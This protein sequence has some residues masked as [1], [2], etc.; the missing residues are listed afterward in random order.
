MPSAF[1]PSGPR[2][3]QPPP[4]CA[5][6]RSPR[7]PTALAAL[8][9]LM[10]STLGPVA[11]AQPGKPGK[12]TAPTPRPAGA[13]P[14]KPGAPKAAGAAPKARAPAPAKPGDAK[15]E[16]ET[17]AQVRWTATTPDEMLKL[18]LERA[19][20]AGTD[21]AAGL[22]VASYLDERAEQGAARKGLLALAG[23][24]LAP[25]LADDA[26]WLAKW[27]T[28]SPAGEPWSGL[29]NVAYDPG[30]DADGLV[31]AFAVLGPF[32][33]TGGG[34]ERKEGPEA[35]GAKL[36][37]MSARYSW[38]VY[39]VAWRRALPSSVTA[40][41]L[42]LDLY[43]HPRT[44]SCSYLAS[45]VRLP[46]HKG[47]VLLHVAASGAVRV[48]WDGVDVAMSSEQHPKA[49]MDRLALALDDAADGEPHLLV[50]KSCTAATADSGHVRARFTDASYQPVAVEASSGLAGFVPKGS[51]SEKADK[52]GKPGAVGKPGGK[53]DPPKGAPGATPAQAPKGTPGKGAKGAPAPGAK[54]AKGAA[55]A[56]RL[57]IRLP[58][59]VARVPTTLERALE[60][61]SEPSHERALVGAVAR[62]FGGAEDA[63]SPRAP[64]LVDRV[65]RGTTSPDLLAFA[66]WI[67]PFGASRSGWLNLALTRAKEKGDGASAAFAQRRLALSHTSSN[68][69]E[70]G[71]TMLAEEPFRSAQDH[72]ARLIRAHAKQA[73]RGAGSARVATEELLALAREL[74]ARTPLLVWQQLFD[75]GRNDPALRLAAARAL[76]PLDVGGRGA[77]YVDAFRGVGGAAL[78][79]A[80]AEALPHLTDATELIHVG[81]A[82]YDAGRYAW[83]REALYLATHLSPNEAAG[84][85]ALAEARRA[86]GRV[87][88]RG[89][90]A[91]EETERANA[92]LA[93]ARDL[94]PGDELVRAELDL[95]EGGL[96][97]D[98]SARRA[99]RDERFLPKPTEFLDRAKKLPAKKGEHF[100]RQLH[101]VRVVTYHNDKRVSQLMHFAK[102]IVVEPRT[103]EQRYEGNIPVEGEDAEIVV[104]RVHRR[105]GTV[106]MPEEQA[107]G[108]R[109][110]IKWPELKTGDVVEVAVRSW[111]SGPV[112][113]RGDPPYY[114]IDYVGSDETH[115]ILYN[116]VV[117]DVP[118][119]GSSLA[120]DVIGGKADRVTS[121]VSGGRK[122]ERYI[123][124]NPPSIA[125][126]PLAP[127]ASEVLPVLVGST[128]ASW[129][130]FR[131]WYR[132]AV[133]GFT[134]P[135]DEIRR[136]AAELTK[137]KK[138]QED[139]LRA[140]FEFV[141]DDIRYVNY[142]SGEWWLPNRPQQL[143]AR[144]QGDCDDKAMLLISLLR[145]IG[146]EAT[147][148][149]VQ[150][151]Y[152]AQPRLLKS[153]K[154]AIPMFD[155]GIAYLPGKNGQPGTWLDATSPE[156]RLG[157]L[158]SM[159]ARAVA[160]FVHE[161]PAKIV[162][163]PSSAPAEHGVDALW[164]IKLD[165]NGGGELTAK[166]T[167]VGDSA[168]ALRMNLKQ[169]DAQKQWLER[170]LEGQLP[171]VDVGDSTFDGERKGG[172]ALLTYG[173][174]SESFARK[175]GKELAVPVSREATFTSR[176]APLVKRT[177]P[178]V[179][180]PGLAPGHQGRELT[181][182]A[183]PGFAF[184]ELP[185]GGE[186]QGGD[187]GT[188]KLS[189]KSV[190]ADKV[191]VTSSVVFDMSTIPVEK[192]G[193]WRGWLQRVDG[194]MNQ[195]VR[196]VPK[197]D[198]QRPT[199]A[200]PAAPGK[201]TGPAKK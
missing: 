143:L 98:A 92:A 58:K 164:T 20:A 44:E 67:A 68:F 84:F 38:G 64:G 193:A 177:L 123:W 102:E 96:D 118:E 113:R 140:L 176:L 78:E 198:G 65:A 106:V 107:S 159:D 121:E 27:L 89:T 6:A 88:G 62:T 54:G 180:P 99:L 161:G 40:R 86:A 104:A 82:L 73:M 21:A 112:G 33:D 178:V 31:R 171:A 71:L 9:A 4:A 101:W 36:T 105:D 133:K 125:D 85:R 200:G 165:D 11:D 135:D 130:D 174:R 30:R 76:A 14:A 47:Q 48:S 28:P 185:P 94:E 114:F 126:E 155:H 120:I 18:A 97:G 124:D 170:Y 186:A 32:Q 136:L 149:L 150:T 60:V 173:A 132:G 179:L 29:R 77:R 26:R 45:K 201:P 59:G 166:E 81:R 56:E 46:A 175:E 95:R 110:F 138:T 146:V 191:V 156:S 66:G 151:R 117:I 17:F 181:L 196:L 35:P 122:V 39:E 61:G 139:K 116:E 128:F 154:V 137:G 100:D 158:P 172:A 152:T 79:V 115:P 195:A 53:A 153:D 109:P 75:L 141:A 142:V 8:L 49:V 167:H 5:R 24:G 93:R 57:E 41:G 1:E 37:D 42:P 131:E 189:F 80:A 2:E 148:V 160:L 147:E 34:L 199:P 163:T 108:R 119:K 129:D 111:T 72:E 194:L 74:G 145:A 43:V 197:A 63:Q 157:P 188:A 134:E 192:Y 13:T 169:K 83:A 50:V 70:W 168:F 184:G 51:A 15:A 103:E 12:P 183:P 69:P 162:D 22:L 190:G 23:S 91:P 25:R 19:K 87:E 10:V 187:Y 127:R 90:I 16:P 182:V 3:P 7:A 52:P 55:K 144:R